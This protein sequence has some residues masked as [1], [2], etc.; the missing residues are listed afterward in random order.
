METLYIAP[1]NPKYLEMLGYQPV[2]GG[3]HVYP[4]YTCVVGVSGRVTQD[5]IFTCRKNLRIEDASH[6]KPK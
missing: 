6:K 1:R 4:T 3:G 2:S 5:P